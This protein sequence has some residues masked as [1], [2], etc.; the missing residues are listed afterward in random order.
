MQHGTAFG[1]V[2]IPSPRSRD[3]NWSPAI[4]E[5]LAL[6]SAFQKLGYPTEALFVIGYGSGQIQFQLQWAATTFTVDVPDTLP[7][8]YLQEVWP[9]A[10]EWWNGAPQDVRQQVYEKSRLMA[11]GS[12]G[13]VAALVTKGLY[14]VT[15]DTKGVRA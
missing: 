8:D 12:V 6:H 2:C 4:I 9:S 1:I 10:I 7:Y 3:L 14:P 15:I 5:L 13:L 11:Q